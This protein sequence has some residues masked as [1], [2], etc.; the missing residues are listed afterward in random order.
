M[1]K[2]N[3]KKTWWIILLMFLESLFFMF[4][5]SSIDYVLSHPDLF[6]Y[7]NDY[8]ISKYSAIDILMVSYVSF[9][10]FLIL[11]LGVFVWLILFKLFDKFKNK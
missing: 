9:I 4:A 6:D 11:S 1:R 8:S 2:L 7:L 3:L 5:I 10:V